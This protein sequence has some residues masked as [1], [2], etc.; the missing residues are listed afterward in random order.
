MAEFGKLYPCAKLYFI[1]DFNE[2]FVV[3]L[4]APGAYDRNQTVEVAQRYGPR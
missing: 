3:D 2:F 4:I 1:K